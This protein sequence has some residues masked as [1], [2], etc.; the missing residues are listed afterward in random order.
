MSNSAKT[1][2]VL[3]KRVEARIKHLKDGLQF[4]G[5]REYREDMEKIQQL[6]AELSRLKKLADWNKGADK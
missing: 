4:A 5:Y 3:I 1:A 6:E 2:S